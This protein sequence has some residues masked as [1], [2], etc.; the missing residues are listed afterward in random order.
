MLVEH[1]K[2]PLVFFE[3]LRQHKHVDIMGTIPTPEQE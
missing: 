2:I 1:F 3:R